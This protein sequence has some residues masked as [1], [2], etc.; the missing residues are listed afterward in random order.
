MSRA[1]LPESLLKQ[2]ESLAASRKMASPVEII[3]WS[4]VERLAKRPKRPKRA[5]WLRDE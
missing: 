2:M 5:Y 3:H 4:E 1:P